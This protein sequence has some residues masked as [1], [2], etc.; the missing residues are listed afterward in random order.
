MY[1]GIRALGAAL[2]WLVFAANSSAGTL[3]AVKERGKLICGV[4]Q[5]L[6]GFS[7][8]GPD[9]SWSGLDVDFCRALAAAILGDA[10]R[11]DYI[12]LSTNERFDALASGKIDLLARNSTWTLGREAEFALTFVGVTYYDGQG[13][14]LPRAANILSSLELDGSRVCVQAATTSEANL[15][16]YFTA[17]NMAYTAI[18][19]SSSVDSLA[20]YKDGRCNVL[21]SD[22]SQLYS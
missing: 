9:G 13:F 17:N 2:L 22:I 19:T 15:R 4:N 10:E 3:D 20:A 16:D 14:M 5:G 7:A 18:V 21:T 8:V 12:P 6:A 1:S 11:V